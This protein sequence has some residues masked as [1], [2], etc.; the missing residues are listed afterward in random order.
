[1]KNRLAYFLAAMAAVLLA[2]CE[3][4]ELCMDHDICRGDWT[5]N[6]RANYD[7]RWEYPEEAT[8]TQ[9]EQ[10]W[11]EEFGRTYASL[12]PGIPGGL[13]VLEYNTTSSQS[14]ITNIPAEGGEVSFTPTAYA[15]IMYNNDTEYIVFEDLSNPATTMATTRTRNRSSYFGNRLNRDQ[16][17]EVTV[18]QPDVLF[19]SFLRDA[20]KGITNRSDLTVEVPMVP[21]TYT[22]LV[23]CKFAHGLKYA[24]LVRGALAGMA[25]G[26]YLFDGSTPDEEVTV[27]FDGTVES[28]GLEAAV[29]TFGVPGYPAI[30]T[31]GD[32]NKQYL[33]NVEVRLTN[34][35]TKT[36]DFDV[37]DQVTKQPR[38]GVIEVDGLVI[39]DEEGMNNSGGFDVEVNGWGDADVIP[40]PF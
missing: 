34:G 26:V 2:S 20:R 3:N 22:Y 24:A 4:K 9:W 13:R 6:V 15:A 12:C 29:R 7:L 8:S 39:T 1:M 33:L 28:W 10:E 38:G 27:L 35:D 21:V 40:L 36:F 19:C 31:R 17:E 25:S 18:N 23:R 37:T 11:K 14:R 5:I 16:E 32:E 30:Y